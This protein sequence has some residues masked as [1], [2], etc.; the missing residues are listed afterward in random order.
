MIEAI[1][2]VDDTIMEKYL[3]REEISVEEIK[4]CFKKRHIGAEAYPGY[5]RYCFQE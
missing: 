1:A 2:D 4:G 5:L 3:R